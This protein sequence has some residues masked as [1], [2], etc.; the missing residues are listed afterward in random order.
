MAKRQIFI[1]TAQIVDSTGLFS[2]LN[3]YPK[4]FDSKNYGNDI[5]KAQS[6]ALGEY[7]EVLGALYKRDDRQLQ[8]AICM[9]ASGLILASQSIGQIAD[10]PDSE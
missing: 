5:D 3:G 8:T 4:T 10:V 7:H 6:K 1:T 2:T 9:T